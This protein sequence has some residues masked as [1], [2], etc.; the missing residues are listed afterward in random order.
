[1]LD[2][3]RNGNS[4]ERSVCQRWAAASATAVARIQTMSTYIVIEGN[5]RVAG[6][7]EAE[8]S[9]VDILYL[10]AAWPEKNTPSSEVRLANVGGANERDRL[11]TRATSGT[12]GRNRRAPVVFGEPIG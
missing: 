6:I 2:P 10:Y 3:A 7:V 5:E 12:V 4:L 11:T 1:M 9:I 8:Q